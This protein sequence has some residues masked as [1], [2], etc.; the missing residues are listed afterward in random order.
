MLVNRTLRLI[1]AVIAGY[2]VMA[3]IVI[4]GVMAAAKLLV[5]AGENPGT[6]YLVGNV[7]ISFLA[8]LSG[9]YVAANFAKADAK[10]ATLVLAA[11]VMALGLIL[12]PGHGQPGWYGLVIPFIGAAGVVLGGLMNRRMSSK[13]T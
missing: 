7:A 6:G 2:I 9:G 4:L 11:V 8:A 1:G 3:L 12:E 13:A 10:L 5:P